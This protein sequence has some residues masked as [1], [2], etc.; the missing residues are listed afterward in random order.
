MCYYIISY[1]SAQIVTYPKSIKSVFKETEG[2]ILKENSHSKVRIIIIFIY[3]IYKNPLV[4][5]ADGVAP[6]TS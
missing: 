1:N 4:F 3:A 5:L 6:F 2:F